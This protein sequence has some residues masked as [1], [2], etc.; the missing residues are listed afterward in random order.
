M[1]TISI[2]IIGLLL[3][4]TA[5]VNAQFVLGLGTEFGNE[6][7]KLPQTNPSY[8]SA[9]YRQLEGINAYYL[10]MGYDFDHIEAGCNFGFNV[11]YLNRHYN[12]TYPTAQRTHHYSLEGYLQAYIN[13]ETRIYPIIFLSAGYLFHLPSGVDYHTLVYQNRSAFGIGGGLVANI[14]SNVQGRF[15]LTTGLTKFDLCL[16]YK[17][18]R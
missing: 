18:V 13:N 5:K 17:F 8:P 11:D 15:L 1:R 9:L 3:A 16:N 12:S 2:V 4:A 14:F 6:I 7:V 10:R